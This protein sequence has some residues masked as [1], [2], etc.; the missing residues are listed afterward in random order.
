MR[1]FTEIAWRPGYPCLRCNRPLPAEA[2]GLLCDE[3]LEHGFGRGVDSS[4]GAASEVGY[5]RAA[6]LGVYGGQLAHW[7]RQLKFDGRPELAE[8]LGH[9]LAWPV[10]ARFG[11]AP[12]DQGAWR[13]IVVP[14]PL[15]PKR[16]RERGY[17]QAELLAAAL[18][19]ALGLRHDRQALVRAVG[20]APQSSLDRSARLQSLLGAFKPGAT[21]LRRSPAERV[22]DSDVLLVDDV[23]TTGAT[24]DA[25]ACVLKDLGARRVLGCTVAVGLPLRVWGRQRTCQTRPVSTDLSPTENTH[26]AGYQQ[27]CP[28]YAQEASAIYPQRVGHGNWPG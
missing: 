18:A 27:S 11:P 7:I 13:A 19:T 12:T 4:T 25:C 23:L 2:P 3:C 17:N 1:C 8:P 28:H 5:D 9:L 21:I 16:R 22:K 20:G 15:H 26:L 24:L 14:V 10:R 6:S